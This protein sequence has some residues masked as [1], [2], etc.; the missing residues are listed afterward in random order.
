MRSGR[1]A[2]ATRASSASQRS[3]AS[4]TGQFV[5]RVAV[6]QALGLD[7]AHWHRR[8]VALSQADG[9]APRDDAQPPDD[10]RAF[11]LAGQQLGPREPARVLDDLRPGADVVRDESEQ[12]SV[13][14]AVERL[15]VAPR[16][17]GMDGRDAVAAMP[18]PFASGRRRRAP[19]ERR[20][21]SFRNSSDPGAPGGT[22]INRSALGLSQTTGRAARA[23][24]S[25]GSPCRRVGARGAAARGEP[26]VGSLGGLGTVL[27]GQPA[28]GKAGKLGVIDAH[29]AGRTADGRPSRRPAS[30]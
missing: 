15:L 29:A 11:R 1:P 26:D 2:S 20:P 8:P 22:P 19:P 14:G 13:V 27:H 6:S 7:G 9:L 18:P 28:R 16:R 24:A 30:R 4:P 10:A 12:A 5:D 3:S 23:S 17:S 21:A 25:T